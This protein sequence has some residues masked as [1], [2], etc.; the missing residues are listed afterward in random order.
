[1]CANRKCLSNACSP[2]KGFAR[3][4]TDYDLRYDESLAPTA[5]AR[6]RNAQ[7]TPGAQA[8]RQLAAQRAST[9][10]EQR[11]IDGFMADAHGLIVREVDRQAAGDLLRAPGVRPPPALPRSMSAAFPGHGRAANR[12]PAWSDDHASQSF[13]HIGSQSRVER[14]LRLLWAASGSLGVPLRCRRAILQAAA[15][16]G[17]VAPQLSGDRRHRPP[18]PASD[19]LH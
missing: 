16:S 3:P 6:T 9:L 10:N 2:A 4:R 12:S 8:G 15:S 13:L 7:R 14:K 19:L 5:G 1:M 11:L 17:G 18:E